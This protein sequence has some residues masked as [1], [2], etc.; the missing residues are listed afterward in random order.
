MAN[1]P[2][3][4]AWAEIK[5]YY[6]KKQEAPP[7][8]S[9]AVSVGTGIFPDKNMGDIDIFGKNFFRLT[10]MVKHVRHLIEMLRNAVSC[11]CLFTLSPWQP[12]IY[13]YRGD[14]EQRSYNCT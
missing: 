2:S 13:N 6:A 1:N 12:N 11:P 3:I 4:A 7:H 10:K 5:H 8:I 9:M 14:F